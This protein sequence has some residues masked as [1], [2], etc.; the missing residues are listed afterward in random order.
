MKQTVR[1][2]R[3]LYTLRTLRAC[4]VP[5]GFLGNEGVVGGGGGDILKIAGL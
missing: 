2:D 3:T 5:V 1:E 4:N